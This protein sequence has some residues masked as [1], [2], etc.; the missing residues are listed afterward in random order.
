MGDKPVRA[1]YTY[2][3]SFLALFCAIKFRSSS[4]MT[5]NFF[6]ESF[7]VRISTI[8]SFD[9]VRDLNF[10]GDNSWNSPFLCRK[11]VAISINISPKINLALIFFDN[12]SAK[13]L[14]YK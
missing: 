1:E 7:E 2:R 13:I 4:L 5:L 9:T 8:I 11:I 10:R 3:F 6:D 12:I 14:K